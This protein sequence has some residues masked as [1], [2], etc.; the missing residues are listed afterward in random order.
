MYLTVLRSK[1][2]Q[3]RVTHA[4]LDYEGSCA[5]D[6]AL[7]DAAGIGED[8]LVHIHNLENGERFSTYTIRG[9]PGSGIISVN[10]AAAHKVRIGDRLEICAYATLTPEQAKSHRPIVL[11]CDE[12]N[13]LVQRA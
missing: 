4:E 9:E 5:I 7:L 6:A 11:R 1:L 8:E 2:D 13:R 12:R 3:V 10:G